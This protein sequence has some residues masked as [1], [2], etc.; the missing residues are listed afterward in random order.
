MRQINLDHVFDSA[1]S[2]MSAESIRMNTIASNMANANSVGSSEDS[3]YHTKTPI[4]SEVA[5]SIIKNDPNYELAGGVKVTDI[6]EST[7]PLQRR[8]EPGHPLADKD[9]YVYM[10]DVNPIEQMASMIAASKEYQA[11]VEVM[12]TTKNL[13]MHTLDVIDMK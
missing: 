1:S 3:T 9:G 6:Q 7:K 2:G 12:N 8:Y 13:I 11:D 5:E 4:F 10:T